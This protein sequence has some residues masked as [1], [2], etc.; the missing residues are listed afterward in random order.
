[1]TRIAIVTEDDN[2]WALYAW[3]R[4]I[5]L[6]RSE[7]YE[8]AGIWACPSILSGMRGMKIY[9][10]YLKTFGIYNFL[11]LSL[12]ALIVKLFR[13]T[14]WAAYK[15]ALNIRC[16][17]KSLN[18]P[19]AHC[20]SP[21]DP[22]FISQIKSG[23]TDIMLIMVSNILKSDALSSVNLAVINKH[24]SA[25]PAN[26]GLFPYVWAI[27]DETP[28]GVSYHK[29]IAGIDTGPILYQDLSMPE[30]ALGSMVAYYFHVFHSYPHGILNAIKI[31]L[32]EKE[33][34]P[35]AE[36][37]QSYHGLPKTEDMRLFFSKDGRVIRL[38]DLLLA[39]RMV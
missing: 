17:A 1:M 28:Q 23:N 26:R 11:K 39:L 18:I 25:L 37:V 36:C 13:L 30:S 9:L 38:K 24:A 29:T 19:F 2:V 27:I 10:W 22:D 35:A 16:F 20:N 14:K 21:N 7:G 4:A 15:D 5:P 6:L 8:F 12:F 32:G 34:S 31:C 3:K 33:A